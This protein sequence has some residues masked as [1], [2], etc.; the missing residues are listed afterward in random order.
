MSLYRP[1]DETHVTMTSW[2]VHEVNF[3][4]GT[5]RHLVGSVNGEGRVS[6]AIQSYD[7]QEKQ[8]ITKSGKVY[9]VQ[10]K[11]GTTANAV[12]VW[13]SWC[14]INKIKPEDFVD[15]TAEYNI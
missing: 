4:D 11:P 5:T 7:P 9:V 8:L 6:S 14:K 12:Y 13:Q 15:V 3:S 1:T 10:G 2:G